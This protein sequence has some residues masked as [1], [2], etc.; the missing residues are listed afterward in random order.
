MSTGAASAATT[1]PR[2]RPGVVLVHGS[3]FKFRGG[4]GVS[5]Y[6]KL[7]AGLAAIDRPLFALSYRDHRARFET[8]ARWRR[9]DAFQALL[10]DVIART[11]AGIVLLEHLP[12]L[13][14]DAMLR[15]KARTGVVLAHLNVD[16]IFN[17]GNG[18]LIAGMARFCDHVFV[19][20][21]P[22]GVAARY[23]GPRYHYWPN[24]VAASVEGSIPPRART[25]DA[26]LAVRRPRA[27]GPRHR[28]N[29]DFRVSY[30]PMVAGAPDIAWRVLDGHAEANLYGHPYLEALAGARIGLDLSATRAPGAADPAPPEERRWYGSDRVGHYF[31]LGLCPLLHEGFAWDE[32]FRPGEDFVPYRSLAEVPDLIRGLLRDGAWERIARTG[33]AAYRERFNERAVATLL[34]GRIAGEPTSLGDWL[35]ARR[36]RDRGA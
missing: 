15:L 8:L 11:G 7:A 24:P 28:P 19:T 13:D 2:G 20:T 6:A 27:I 34:L 9:R 36:D 22:S 10:E 32:L 4:D 3:L 18:A 26:V 29:D 23:P 14:A 25:H 16:P 17:P 21:E 12:R 30:A 5:N 35:D 33:A 31:G 1:A